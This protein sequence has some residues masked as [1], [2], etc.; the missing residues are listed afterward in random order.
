MPYRFPPPWLTDRL[1]RWLRRGS[2][3]PPQTVFISA[4]TDLDKAE[5]VEF[6]RWLGICVAQWAYIDRRLYQIFHHAMGSNQEKSALIF[7]QIRAFNRRLRLVDDSV[8][9]FLSKDE[10]E[11][12]WQLL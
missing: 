10:Y 11:N 6:F 7:Y 5:A 12:E 8:K 9:A 1:G 3:T 2:P 4:I